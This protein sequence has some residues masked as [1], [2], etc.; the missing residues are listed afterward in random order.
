MSEEIEKICE[1]IGE[2]NRFG[3]EKRLTCL[4]YMLSEHK[5]EFNPDFFHKDFC[6]LCKDRL[7]S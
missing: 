3:Y 5:K 1:R 7:M 2:I 6:D 4:E